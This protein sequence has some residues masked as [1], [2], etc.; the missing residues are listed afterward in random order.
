MQTTV[1]VVEDTG[2]SRVLLDRNLSASGYKVIMAEDGLKALEILQSVEVNMILLDLNLPKLNGDKLIQIVRTQLKY[3]VPIIVTSG[4]ID[5]KTI[6]Q[7]NQYK[8]SGYLSKPID[9]NNLHKAISTA[10]AKPGEK[11]T[12]D[13]LNNISEKENAEKKSIKIPVK[14]HDESAPTARTVLIADD[15]GYIRKQTENILSS[16]GYNVITAKDGL[17]A[18]EEIFK[19]KVDLL[20]TDHEMPRMNGI[21]LV[22]Q[23]RERN[24][25]IPVILTSTHKKSTFNQDMSQLDISEFIQKPVDEETL[26]RNCELLIEESDKQIT[27]SGTNVLFITSNN[28]LIKNLQFLLDSPGLTIVKSDSLLDSK[29]KA[30][31]SSIKYVFIDL[32]I[33][34]IDGMEIVRSV[35]KEGITGEKPVYVLTEKNLEAAVQAEIQHLGISKIFHLPMK[36]SE[37]AEEL[38]QLEEKPD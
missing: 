13:K 33:S 26:I 12:E 6:S 4:S 15:H 14:E 20:I 8:I 29:R 22:R 10:L 25:N 28:S 5:K 27:G 36:I 38:K 1:L 31:H 23:L 3:D 34:G 30:K 7:L 16:R 9:M 17:E 11:E 18:F 35:N 32:E 24:I 21:S 19:N 37:L 2:Y